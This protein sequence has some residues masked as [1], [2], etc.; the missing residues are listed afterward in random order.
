MIKS[1]WSKGA[2]DWHAQH[3]GLAIR[4]KVDRTGR[5]KEICYYVS[6]RLDRTAP[7]SC[8]LLEAQKDCYRSR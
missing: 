5:P 1:M 4:I 2:R 7:V 3:R 8:G 6:G